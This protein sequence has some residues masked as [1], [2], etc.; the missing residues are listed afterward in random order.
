MREE[1]ELIRSLDKLVKIVGIIIIPIG[2]TLFI[3]QMFFAG[4]TFSDSITGM[5]A[6]VIGMIPEGLYLFGKCSNGCKHYAPCE[7]K[8]LVRNMKCIETL[9][10]L[11][12]LCV[13]KTGTINREY[14]ESQPLGAGRGERT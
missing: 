14:Y 8:V 11:T 5:V 6:A 1:S 2:L 12:F 4:A 3:Q 7:K 10:E 9:A 13:D